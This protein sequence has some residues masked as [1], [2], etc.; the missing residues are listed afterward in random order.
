[1]RRAGGA[2]AL[3]SGQHPVPMRI[4]AHLHFWKPSCGFDNRPVADNAAYRRDFLPDDVLPD[5][6]ACGIDGAILVQTAPQTAE[7][8]WLIDVALAERR[9]WGVTAWV[10]LAGDAPDYAVLLDRPKVVGIR[11]QLRRI[12]DD[13]F[14]TRPNVVANLRDALDAGLNVTILAEA[15]HY[16]HVTDVLA[17]LPSG[18]V[19]INHLALPFPAV[20]GTLWRAALGE[21]AQRRE[22]YVQLSGL[23]FLFEGRWRG[24]DARAVL[25][26]A[27]AICGPQRLMFASDYPMLLRFATYIEWVRAV[28]D[29]LTAHR[30]AAGDVDAIFS[31]NALRANPRLRVAA[32]T[33]S[34][35]ARQSRVAA[36][37]NTES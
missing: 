4:D 20:D 29:F 35:A 36:S 9:V 32:S 15:R 24:A 31:G 11:A 22:T 7:T 26:D 34:A 14:V 16:R 25:D 37:S 23:P 5:L 21:F 6:D 1:V 30:L 10:D 13:A 19:T 3:T 27:M 12:A 2:V 8:D 33:P 17:R 18:P 28:E